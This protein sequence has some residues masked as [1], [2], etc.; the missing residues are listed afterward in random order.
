MET[1]REWHFV[2]NLAKKQTKTRRGKHQFIGLKRFDGS[3]AWSWLNK[4]IAWVNGTSAGTWRWNKGE[5][6][7]LEKEKCGEMWPNGKYN[8]I[9]CEAKNYYKNPGYVCEKQFCKFMI[10]PKLCYPN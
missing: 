6:N 10:I 5:P 8:N 2:K 7:K 9:P 4:T 3:C 1:K